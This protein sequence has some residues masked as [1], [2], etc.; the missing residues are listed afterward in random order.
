MPETLMGL[1]GMGLILAAYILNQLGKWSADNF[2]FD[3]TN[4]LG[5]A[6]LVLYAVHI[7]G[8]Q[9]WPFIVLNATW[10]LV[11][12]RDVVLYLRK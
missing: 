10:A 11:S 6:M 12:A 7:Q 2:F 5:A 8:W 9:G 1:L 3:A 4:F